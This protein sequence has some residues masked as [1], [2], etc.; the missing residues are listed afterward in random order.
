MKK[1]IFSRDQLLSQKVAEVA[2]RSHVVSGMDSV[3]SFFGVGKVTIWKR[4]MKDR[5]AQKLL[6]TMTED[7]LRRFIIKFVYNDMTSETLTEVRWKRWNNMKK[8]DFKRIGIDEDSNVHRTKRVMF[9]ISSI[10]QFEQ[11][12]EFGNPLLHGYQL[13]EQMKCVPIRYT[14]E[15]FPEELLRHVD[16]MDRETVEVDACDP[17]SGDEEADDDEEHSDEESE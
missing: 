5:E 15:A 14:K 3:S 1:E 2:V 6:E 4:I 13:N 7:S 16:Q 9:A 11:P 10:E 12:H 17:E 8:K